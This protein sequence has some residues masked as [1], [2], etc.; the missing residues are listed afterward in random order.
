MI[1]AGL[2]GYADYDWQAQPGK[3]VSKPVVKRDSDRVGK[4]ITKSILLIFAFCITLVLLQNQQALLGYK[5][6]ELQ[7]QINQLEAKNKRLQYNVENLSSL[8][9]VQ[10]VAENDLGMYQPQ[11]SNM[12]A[13]LSE[14][15][16]IPVVKT[17]GQPVAQKQ[18]SSLQRVYQAMV[19]LFG[20]TRVVGMN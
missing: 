19:N 13:V 17:T 5:K 14:P 7:K 16:S 2:R 20:N 9:R 11:S 1:Q 6:V 18:A 15:K 3:T 12:V 8:D 10:K 4:V